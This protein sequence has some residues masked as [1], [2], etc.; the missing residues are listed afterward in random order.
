MTQ[1]YCRLLTPL[2]VL[3]GCAMQM[4]KKKKKLLECICAH[5]CKIKSIFATKTKNNALQLDTWEFNKLLHFLEN[6]LL[7][8]Q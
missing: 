1:L 6:S 3:R 7:L 4:L 8:F 5:N 2:S